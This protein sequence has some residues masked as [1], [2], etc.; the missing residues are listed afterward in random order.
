M[1]EWIKRTFH[2]FGSPKYFFQWSER[3]LF[4]LEC[5][6]VLL[7]ITGL[8]WGLF[9]APPDYQQGDSVRIIYVHVPAAIWSMGCYSAM[10]VF[11]LVYL[12]WRIKLAGI[13]A[14]SI[15]PV[16]ALMAFLALATGSLWGKPMWGAYWVWDAR[17]TSELILLFLFMGVIMLA[18]SFNDE[19]KGQ[20]PACVLALVGF[21]N[22]PVV[23]YSVEWWQT[24]HQGASITR[25]A[26]PAI[27][28]S[29]LW[30][31]L[32][33][34]LGFFGYVVV[35][36]LRRARARLLERESAASWVQIHLKEK[37]L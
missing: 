33:M 11:S 4:L 32:V 26:K 8:V 21:I 10:A 34:L 37:V 7:L 17:L 31:L 23:H 18:R 2:Q 22:V 25:L 9:F 36:T 35:V 13:L 24:L 29:M 5:S 28:L 19:Q 14:L 1:W 16:G 27:D 6:T 20:L 30:P 12:V 3:W 15:A